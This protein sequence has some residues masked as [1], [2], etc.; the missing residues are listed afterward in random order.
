L[1][2]FWNKSRSLKQLV[3][4]SWIA[5]AVLTL[6]ASLA[7][8]VFLGWLD[9][10]NSIDVTTVDLREKSKVAA[11]TV[12]AEILLQEHGA[13]QSVMNKLKS[14]LGV[15]DI[16]ISESASCVVDSDVCVESND[17][18]VLVTRQI[19][20]VAPAKYVILQKSVPP[21]RSFLNLGFLAWSTL[22]VFFLIVA[23]LII[24]L[25][26]LRREIVEPVNALV[27]AADSSFVVQEDWPVEVKQIGEEL[28]TSFDAK[29][30]AVFA[31]LA[32]G[33][34]H[35]IKTFMHSLLI[36]TDMIGEASD[37]AK[38]LRRLENL[39]NAS[40][41][42]L[43]KIKRI[44]E[45]T[46]VGS[47]EIQ[48]NE[49]E[50]DLVETIKGAVA[51]NSAYAKERRVALSVNQSKMIIAAHDPVQLERALANL[52]KNGIEVFSSGESKLATH[53]E[54]RI[55]VSDLDDS[56]QIAIEDSG[57]GYAGDV[58]HF[59]P[60]KSQKAHGA[61]LGLYITQKIIHGHQ[62]KLDVMKSAV[63]GGAR[64]CIS[65]PKGGVS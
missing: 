50:S 1:G 38:R 18:A 11:R 61:G 60:T 17:G 19:P 37:D 23:G 54:V 45:L 57:P 53:R 10:Q 25:V 7:V 40:K 51:A 24:Q 49:V 2:K 20:Q 22:P 47:R 48:I 4:L 29:E 65:L 59:M 36:A 52:I 64:F 62:G 14:E 12:S 13:V 16:D 32:E 28:R 63:L 41:S 33:V 39:Y 56:V 46:L 3:L 34:I 43:P 26:F 5:P 30:Q 9:Y 6:V 15:A 27:G 42:N 8:F 55:S 35:D 21:L 31:L 44:I 58:S